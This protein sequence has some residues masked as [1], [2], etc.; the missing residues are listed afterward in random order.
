MSK[1]LVYLVL[2]PVNSG[3]RAILSD[4]L[5]NGLDDDDR[6]ALLVSPGEAPIPSDVGKRLDGVANLITGNWSLDRSHGRLEATVPDGATHVFFLSEGHSDPVEQVE[7]LHAW[8]QEADAE[9]ARVIT[10]I[11]CK[12]G[13][14]HP[15]LKRWYDACVHFSDVVLLNRREGVPNQW[16]NEFS[17]RFK[18]QHIPCLLEFV[19]NDEVQNPALILE[20]QARRI[21]ML[22]DDEE[23]WA[24]FDD[25]DSEDL[26]EG[27]VSGREDPYIQK[28]ATGR[29]VKEI[30]NIAKF[31]GLAD[32]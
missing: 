19:K 10:V 15:E 25:D 7:A 31:L 4:L 8:L 26:D 17:S 14:E 5:A 28:L 18:K 24:I 32:D 9:M 3:R 11:N 23:A 29:R 12:L 27:E 22:F 30:P 13:F 2:G 6:P 20:P 21:S 16:M 1:P